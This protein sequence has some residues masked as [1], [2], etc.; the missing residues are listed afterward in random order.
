MNLPGARTGWQFP[1]AWIAGVAAVTAL[2]CLAGLWLDLTILRLF[3]KWVPAVMLAVWVWQAA[4]GNTRNLACAGLLLSALGDLTLEGNYIASGSGI[5]WFAV[6]LGFFLL[7]HC[8]YIPLF[9]SLEHD[10][11]WQRAV[12]VAAYV[13]IF[14]IVIW[15]HLGPMR[16]PVVAYMLVISGM[17]WAALCVRPPPNLPVWQRHCAAWGAVVF[18][19]SDSMIAINKFLAPFTGAR[20]AILLT[21]WVAQFAIASAAV[22]FPRRAAPALPGNG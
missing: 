1:P 21:Y 19:A 17:L 18:A 11:G 15:N 12:P 9:L 14:M 8:C 6:G 3:T 10:K 2:L 7:A 13:A 16:L 22:N 5:P 20:E 4:R